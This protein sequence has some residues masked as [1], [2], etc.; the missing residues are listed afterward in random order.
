MESEHWR[1]GEEAVADAD[2]DGV[3]EIRSDDL[4]TDRQPEPGGREQGRAGVPQSEDQRGACSTDCL[5]YT[6]DAADE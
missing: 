1:D 4:V 2:V 5:L 6:S 3:L